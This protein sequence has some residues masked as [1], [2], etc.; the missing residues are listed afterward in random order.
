MNVRQIHAIMAEI[1]PTELLSIVAPV[2]LA[3]QDITVK[4]VAT[5]FFWITR[6]RIYLRDVF[7]NAANSQSICISIHRYRRL[8]FKSL[9]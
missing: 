6:N 4:P 1:V 2:L 8:F 5:N 3:I 9:Q 7:K